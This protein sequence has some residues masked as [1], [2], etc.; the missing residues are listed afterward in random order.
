MAME[1]LQAFSGA[2]MG[3]NVSKGKSMLA[4]LMGKDIVSKAI[5]IVDD[6]L[7][8]G[9]WATSAVDGEGVRRRE[10]ELIK[11]GRLS[12]FL[13]DTYW[14]K[15]SGAVST[16]NASRSSYKGVPSIGISNLYMRAGM[17]GLDELLK[18]MDT[19]F[20]HNGAYGRTY[21]KYHNRR[22]LSRGA[23]LSCRGRRA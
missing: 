3:D 6:G 17:R 9:G 23:G 22:I 4:K 1:L 8:K 15:I 19:R 11:E 5:S 16:G 20:L 18:T 13:Y 10:T 12:A 21:H 2:F 7:F 14:G